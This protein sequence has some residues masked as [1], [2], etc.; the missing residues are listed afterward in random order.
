MSFDPH[1]RTLISRGLLKEYDATGDQHLARVTGLKGEELAQVPR[2]QQWG[3][4]GNPPLGSHVLFIRLGGG[5]ERAT[6]IGIDHADYSPKDL[7]A[8]EK[9]I[10]DANGNIIKLTG[11]KLAVTGASQILL[12][13]GGVSLKITSAGIDITGGYVK[14]DGHLIDKNH[15]NTG[16]TP[17]ASNTGPPL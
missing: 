2:L 14:H 10:Y 11:S 5:S 13:V 9:A 17:G 6:I 7:A 15:V 1:H 3:Q 8:G 16:V 4:S 12:T